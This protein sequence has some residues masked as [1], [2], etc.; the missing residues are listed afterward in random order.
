MEGDDVEAPLLE[1]DEGLVQRQPDPPAEALG[2]VPAAGVV[3]EDL[4]HG[5]G[6]GGEE[7]SA[8]GDVGEGVAV[9][10]SEE[11]LVDEGAGLEGV[12]GPFA[13]HEP[14]GDAAQLVVDGADESL[15]GVVAAVADLA[16]DGGQITPSFGAHP[17]S[18]NLAEF[19]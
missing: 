1:G 9:E 16:E 11:G 8:V 13:A 6:G 18:L 5:L 17:V 7:V 3:D 15:R 14:A 19:G 10:E 4:A 2:G 12:S